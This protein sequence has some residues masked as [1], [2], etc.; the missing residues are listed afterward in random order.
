M[1]IVLAC[2]L[3]VLTVSGVYA[4][5]P[6]IQRIDV[7]EYGIYTADEKGCHRDAQGINRCERSNVRHAAT[8]LSVPAQLRVQ[9]GMRFKA[10]GVPSGATVPVKRVWI[11]P[12]AGLNSPMV[13]EPIHR[14]ERSDSVKINVTE[15]ISY[16]FD[17]PWELVPGTWTLEYW[18]GNRKLLSKSFMVAK[19]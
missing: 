11:L 1:R 18:D 3:L 5:T 4:E 19:P 9:F 6:Q 8:T 13:K 17:D 7:L 16:T 12:A 15:F 10:V 14:L 2:L